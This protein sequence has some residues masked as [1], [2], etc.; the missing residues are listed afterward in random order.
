MEE[1]LEN[2][3]DFIETAEDALKKS[4]W[5]VAV[6]NYFRA[7]SNICDYLIYK[8]IRI[9]PKNHNERFDLL[10][11]H[12]NDISL[13]IISLFKLYRESYNLKL[14]KEDAHNLQKTTDALRKLA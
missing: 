3:D 12:F 14:T 13:Q 9:F 7:I 4:K 2:A 6:A 8:K 11:K 10:K 5:N 1:L